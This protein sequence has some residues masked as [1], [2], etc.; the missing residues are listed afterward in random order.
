M[1]I[2]PIETAPRDGT[3][4][5]LFTRTKTSEKH[6]RE[7]GIKWIQ[8][9]RIGAFIDGSWQG[10]IGKPIGWMPLDGGVE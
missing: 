2:Q 3:D 1:T 4:I 9:E 6:Y 8:I 7:T 10:V 5:K